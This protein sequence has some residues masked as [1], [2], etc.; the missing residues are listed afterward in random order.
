MIDVGAM[1][2]DFE[3]KTD[4][5]QTVRLGPRGVAVGTEASVGSN[6]IWKVNCC[7]RIRFGL[8]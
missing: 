1:A 3:L 4:S 8:S 5:G 2:P 7:S 6:G